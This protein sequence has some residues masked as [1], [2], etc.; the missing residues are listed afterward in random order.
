[1]SAPL[2]TLAP[3]DYL[4]DAVVEYLAALSPKDF[5]ALIAQARPPVADM[6]STVAKHDSAVQA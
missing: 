6:K 4:T 5:A 2:S 3:V 1:M